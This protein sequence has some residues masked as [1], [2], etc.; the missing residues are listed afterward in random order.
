MSGRRALAR[1]AL[2]A[3]VGLAAVGTLVVPAAPAAA[4]PPRPTDHRSTVTAVEPPTPAVR[5]EVVGGDAFLELRVDAGTEVVVEGYGGEPYLRFRVD[6]SVERNRRSTATYL[7]EDRQGAVDLPSRADDEAAPD[8]ERVGSG[9]AYAWHDHRIHWMGRSEPPGIGPGDVVQTWA[10]PLTVDGTPT[11]IRG[12]LVLADTVSPLPWIALA[13]AAAAAV[14][15]S[16]RRRALVAQAAPA[17]AAGAALV[18]GWAEHAAAPAGSG[19]DPLLVAVPL[20]G[21][22]AG[23]AGLALRRS[24]LGPPA[25]LASAAAVVGWAALRALVLWTPVLPTEMP[26]GLDRTLTAL[27]LGLAVA[28][29]GVVAWNPARARTMPPPSEEGEGLAD[30]GTGRPFVANA[31]RGGG[32]PGRGATADGSPSPP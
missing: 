6:G 15:V 20:A 5:A 30:D 4:D 25:T 29:A 1:P 22:V 17:A 18:A 31:A 32:I 27:A 21:L 16:A 28:G 11:E 2:V 14:V 26:A 12:E 24:T 3:A 7:N 23:V 10:V 13:L 9:G 19:S 8:W